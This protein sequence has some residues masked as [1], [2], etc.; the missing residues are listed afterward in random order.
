MVKKLVKEELVDFVGSDVHNLNQLKVFE[1][2][3]ISGEIPMIERCI[4]RTLFF[5]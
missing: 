3:I 1:N 2:E 4:E 5:H